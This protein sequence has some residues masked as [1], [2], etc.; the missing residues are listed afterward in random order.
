MCWRWECPECGE[1]ITDTNWRLYRRKKVNH[2]HN[3]C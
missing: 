3:R 2:Y 1:Q